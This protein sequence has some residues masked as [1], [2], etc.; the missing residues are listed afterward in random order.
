[1][2]SVFRRDRARARTGEEELD[3]AHEPERV[4]RALRGRGNLQRALERR[5]VAIV[6]QQNGGAGRAEIGH[7][8]E[9]E[10]HVAR[11]FAGD[12]V[13]RFIERLRPVVV[14]TAEEP[15]VNDAAG[16]LL[17]DFHRQLR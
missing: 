9:I 14:Q 17:N 1:M 6:L 8:G 4:A 15:E 3:E 7:A 5:R 16:A 13:K 11:A 2:D 10:P 12:F